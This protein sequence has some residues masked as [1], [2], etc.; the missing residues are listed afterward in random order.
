[1]NVI[2]SGDTPAYGNG[3]GAG[4][5]AGGS[6]DISDNNK[7]QPDKKTDKNATLQVL[8]DQPSRLTRSNSLALNESALS[9]SKNNK[10]SSNKKV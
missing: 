7:K 5:G 1:M 8:N 6:A 3:N 10:P 4:S 9:Q 2:P